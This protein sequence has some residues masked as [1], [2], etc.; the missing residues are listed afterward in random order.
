MELRG[1]PLDIFGLG[2]LDG[3]AEMSGQSAGRAPSVGKEVGG[4]GIEGPRRAARGRRTRPH[5]VPVVVAGAAVGRDAVEAHEEV[6]PLPV[7]GSKVDDVRRVAQGQLPTIVR[8]QSLPGRGGPEA[9][10]GAL[11][12][13]KDGNKRKREYSGR[14]SCDKG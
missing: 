10:F 9:Y 11:S 14:C 13:R 7:L 4:G 6:I 1:R 5:Y 8:S 12:G 3:H 2:G